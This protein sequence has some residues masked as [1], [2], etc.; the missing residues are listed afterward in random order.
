[1]V[2]YTRIN[3]FKKINNIL[4]QSLVELLM[5]IG[6]ASAILP[7][8]I[9]GFVSSREGAVNQDLRLRAVAYL[10]E[11]EEAV[12]VVREKDWNS[13]A[14][15]GIYHPEVLGSTWILT[16]NFETISDFTR[17][18]TIS[19]IN[20]I[21]PSIKQVDLKVSWGDNST[22]FVSSKLYLSRYLENDVYTETIEAQF[23]LGTLTNTIVTNSSGGEVQLGSGGHGDWC[24]PN[25][26]IAS[27]DLPKSGVANAISATEGRLVA[28]TGDN[29]SGVSFAAI[30]VTNTNPPSTSIYGT[31]D[32]YKTNDVYN[33]QNYAYLATDTNSKEIVIIDISK[34]PFTEVGYFNAS[35]SNSSASV[36]VKDNVGYMIQQNVLRNFDLTSKSGSRPA[37]D[38]DGVTI[39]SSASSIF[40]QGN[41]A[42]VS[43]VNTDKQLQ[44]IDISNPSNLTVVGEARLNGSEGTDVIVNSTGTRAYVVTKIS[45]QPEFFIVNTTS[46][47]GVQPVISSFDSNGM[48]PKAVTVVSGNRAIMV[49]VSG[50]E[51][52]VVNIADENSLSYCGGLDI[53]TGVNGISSVVEQDGDAYSYIITGESTGELKIIEGGPGGGSVAS[54]GT[55]VSSAF[56]A[57]HAVSFN[58]FS[59]TET[60]PPNTSI[61]YQV[62]VANMVSGS[63][64]NAI[65][66]FVDS[67]GSISLAGQCFKYKATLTS[68]DSSATPILESITIN[69]SP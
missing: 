46:K 31:F 41:Y 36:F 25:L 39:A 30:N 63:C 24:D 66:N 55:F 49:G 27:L 12:R 48:N 18:I 35:G 1:M 60:I 34:L 3:N 6:I 17:D 11:A 53:N 61:T 26:S 33:D 9:T 22:Q 51:Y 32:G 15:N 40:V 43:I 13:F 44:I 45:G 7:A 37:I 21:D 57:G 29:A 62:A 69:Y 8:V 59:K 19:D 52:Q 23:K 56:N 42:Y 64:T 50:T 65:Y 2:Q 58:R 16:N 28:G 5:A 68:S 54:S 20:P 67:S 4:G 47:T 14:V 38:S 10:K